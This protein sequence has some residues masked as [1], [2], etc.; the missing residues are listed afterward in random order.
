MGRL[1]KSAIPLNNGSRKQ[2]VLR[3]RSSQ[4]QYGF[5]GTECARCQMQQKSNVVIPSGWDPTGDDVKAL[6]AHLQKQYGTILVKKDDDELMDWVSKFLALFPGQTEEDF[7]NNFVTTIGRKIYIPFELGETGAEGWGLWSQ[8]VVGVHEHQHVEQYRGFPIGHRRKTH[9]FM[10]FARLYLSKSKARATFEANAY[11]TTQEMGWWRSK[12]TQDVERIVQ[13]LAA[14]YHLSDKEMEYARQIL[15][16]NTKMVEQGAILTK[17][18]SIAID[19]LN[20]RIS[21]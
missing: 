8:I 7:L 20:Q 18:S 21:S 5:V 19:F 17:A 10:D 3:C 4:T 14:V 1:W 6:W 11:T 9:G 15:L 13:P 16:L 12:T 2:T